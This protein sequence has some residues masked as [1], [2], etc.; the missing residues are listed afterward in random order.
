MSSASVRYAA[1]SSGTDMGAQINALYDSLPP[2]GGVI[3]VEESASFATPIVFGTDGKPVLLI[4]LPGDVV[5]LTYTGSSG[6]AIT[7]DY[8]TGHRMGHGL[9]DLTLTGPGHETDTVGVVF[10][11]DHGAEGI[12]FR[13]FKIQSFGTNLRMG[14][15]TWLAYFQHG[16]VRDGGINVLLPSGL[17]EAGEQIAFNHVT[18]ADAP[19]PHQNSVWVQGGG[20]EIV[21]TDCSFDHAQLRIGNGTDSAAQVVVKGS[22]FENPNYGWGGSVNYDYVV[23]DNHPGN[24]LRITDSYFLQD[25]PARG[26]ARFVSVWGGKIQMSGIGMFTPKASPL[27]NFAVLWNQATMDM[28]GF[29]DLS[30]NITGPVCAWQ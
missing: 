26:P 19:P 27:T 28:Y 2:A 12:D 29:N 4:G 17:T 25:A 13:D 15:H 1:V 11:G 21:F 16:M 10:G 23:V 30:G 5:T 8:G 18:F 14:S 9:R 7:F 6:V 20:Q 3:Y 22:H 24:Y